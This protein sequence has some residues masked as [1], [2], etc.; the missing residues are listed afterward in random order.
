MKKLKSLCKVKKSQ[1]G[2]LAGE[3][4]ETVS[5]PRYICEKCLRVA[6]KKKHLCS[7][8]RLADWRP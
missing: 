7:P 4:V 2:E 6:A 3:I 5:H 8:R 1:R